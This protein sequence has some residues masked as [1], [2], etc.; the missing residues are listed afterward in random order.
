MIKLTVHLGS[1]NEVFPD[2]VQNADSRFG[3][4]LPSSKLCAQRRGPSSSRLWKVCGMPNDLS[5]EMSSVAQN[6]RFLVNAEAELSSWSKS[7]AALAVDE[8]MEERIMRNVAALCGVSLPMSSFHLG[9]KYLKRSHLWLASRSTDEVVPSD[10]S[11]HDSPTVPIVTAD[12]LIEKVRK[13]KRQ[14]IAGSD[15]RGSQHI[16]LFDSSSLG[17]LLEVSH[18][19][20]QDYW[21]SRNETNASSGKRGDIRKGRSFS[22]PISLSE[23]MLNGPGV[24]ASTSSAA[25]SG[26]VMLC[27]PTLTT[28]MTRKYSR[29]THWWV[30]ETVAYPGSHSLV[31]LTI[32]TVHVPWKSLSADFQTIDGLPS[33]MRCGADGV[34]Y[35]T[36]LDI[37][38]SDATM[39]NSK[40]SNLHVYAP[41][42]RLATEHSVR[43][44]C[45]VFVLQH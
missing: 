29:P 37:S 10:N 35:S 31:D 25:S 21:T 12:V 24:H 23:F 41:S 5:V 22:E 1:R 15:E 6:I 7:C 19:N 16:E 38:S 11:V 9:T 43:S 39:K 13:S 34:D 2:V 32:T 30:D 27:V 26:S 42:Y 45:D 3:N 36:R 28:T 4:E 44:G 17:R 40:G 18:R 14:R 8:E 33:S 20:C